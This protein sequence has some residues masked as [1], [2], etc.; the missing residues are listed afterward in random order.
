MGGA[1]GSPD[2]VDA[3]QMTRHEGEM[4]D[5][6]ALIGSYRPCSKDD[7]ARQA[8]PGELLCEEHLN[9]G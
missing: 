7:C 5:H 2:A 3:F 9:E 1:E 6:D 4:P 8:A